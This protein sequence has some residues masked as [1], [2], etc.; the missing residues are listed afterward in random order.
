MCFIC[1]RGKKQLPSQALWDFLHKLARGSRLRAPR[2]PR[3]LAS[4]LPI[5]TP[6]ILPIFTP[7]PSRTSFSLLPTVHPGGRG[8]W[9]LGK[10]PQTGI[11]QF[12]SGER[13]TTCDEANA[14][15]RV[16]VGFEPACK[17]ARH[18][19]RTGNAGALL[20]RGWGQALPLSAEL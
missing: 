11:T 15:A 5:F 6:N 14:S 4:Y 8:D 20:V 17:G 10:S 2:A 1:F 3:L 19:A 7:K 18:P 13:L 9:A 16:D 12:Q